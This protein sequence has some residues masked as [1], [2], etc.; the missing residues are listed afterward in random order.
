MRRRRRSRLFCICG[1]L[2]LLCEPRGARSCGMMTWM[3][4]QRWTRSRI[5]SVHIPWQHEVRCERSGW[6]HIV[7][8]RFWKSSGQCS[9]WLTLFTL[10]HKKS[11]KQQ[12]KP[13]LAGS[14]LQPEH[15]GSPLVF[16]KEDEMNLPLFLLKTAATIPQMHSELAVRE[17]ASGFSRG[18]LFLWVFSLESSHVWPNLNDQLSSYESAEVVSTPGSLY[19]N[20]L[21][22]KLA[23]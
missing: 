13:E 8:D 5:L 2:R 12:R 6:G 7:T 16:T 1:F 17:Q 20:L 3:T 10:S 15:R 4:S 21:K 23:F 19:Q 14:H 11:T 18:I 9:G 22:P